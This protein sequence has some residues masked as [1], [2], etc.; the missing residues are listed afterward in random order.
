MQTTAF[1]NSLS[2]RTRTP[3]GIWQSWRYSLCSYDEVLE[4][5]I[6]REGNDFE[7]NRRLGKSQSSVF[8][9]QLQQFLEGL[10]ADD[11]GDL[12]SEVCDEAV[13]LEFQGHVVPHKSN[14]ARRV[15]HGKESEGQRN[16]WGMVPRAPKST[17]THLA[18]RG[19]LRNPMFPGRGIVTT[20]TPRIGLVVD[21]SERIIEALTPRLG[22][23]F[24]ECYGATSPAEAEAILQNHQVTHLVCDFD[25]GGEHPVGTDLVKKW[26][27]QYP[28]IVRAIIFSGTRPSMIPTIPEVDAVLEKPSSIVA[29]K[30]ALQ[31]E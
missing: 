5:Y 1:L 25:L 15:M 21:D 2:C 3:V 8:H 31:I 27:L 16:I 22:K 14:S 13:Q 17:F 30:A 19:I 20:Q 29:L 6:R 4:T 28:G 26:R 11:P 18:H 24:D 12:M 9:P 7:W 10:L 23:F